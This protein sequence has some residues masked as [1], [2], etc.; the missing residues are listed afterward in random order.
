MKL[1][2]VTQSYYPRYGGV[3]EHVAHTAREL[4]A[5]GHEV[6]VVT[7]RPVGCPRRR[8]RTSCAS[9]RPSS[10]RSRARSSTSRSGRT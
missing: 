4:R 2:L 7:G 10:C 8:A 5:R 9:A 1:A 6:T 3:T